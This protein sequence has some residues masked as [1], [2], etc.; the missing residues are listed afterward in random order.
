M[1]I[2]KSYFGLYWCSVPLVGLPFF[3]SLLLF[4]NGGA[5]PTLVSTIAVIFLVV[6]TVDYKSFAVMTLLGSASAFFV[7]LVFLVFN[8][9]SPDP[10]FSQMIQLVG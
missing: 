8:I 2:Y 9:I 6:L 7:F 4:K 3:F 10:F 1:S 5:T